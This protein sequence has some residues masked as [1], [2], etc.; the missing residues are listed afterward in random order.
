[1]SSDRPAPA[2]LPRGRH[3]LP[4][5]VV[6]ASQ[7]ERLLQAMLDCVAER[8]Y[9]ATT[10][11][12]VV[13]AAK[14]SRNAFYALF[15]D[16]AACFL[17]LC[18]ELATEMLAELTDPAAADWR[19]ALRLGTARYLRWWQARP[20]FSRTY[21]VELPSAGAR[22]IEQRERQYAAFRDLFDALAAWARREEPDLPAAQ[23]LATRV[24]VLAV[25]ELIAEEVR[26]GRVARLTELTDDV[27]ALIAQ[28]LVGPPVQ[29]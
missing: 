14:V 18:D 21:F 20:A 25:T 7:R 29:L 8:G 26:A 27:V 5:E 10:V 4:L 1:V 2:V 19:Q 12:Q 24:V 3:N 9:E 11:P 17:A 28:L 16:K 13:A 22:A 6:R 15:P 23:P